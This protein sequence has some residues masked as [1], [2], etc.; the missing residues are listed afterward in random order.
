M[1]RLSKLQG[2]PI[3]V[4]V[5]P[6]KTKKNFDQKSTVSA[7]DVDKLITDFNLSLNVTRGIDSSLRSF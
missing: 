1:L 6:D 7:D 2:K 5:Q 4:V 3:Q